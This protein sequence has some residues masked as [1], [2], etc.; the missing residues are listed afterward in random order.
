MNERLW[1][2]GHSVAGWISF[3]KQSLHDFISCEEDPSC[4]KVKIDERFWGYFFYS[5]E[6]MVIKITLPTPD[7]DPERAASY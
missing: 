3:G 4:M 7:K 2:R 1:Y 5:E 6:G